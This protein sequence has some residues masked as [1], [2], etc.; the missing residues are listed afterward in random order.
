MAYEPIHLPH[1]ERFRDWFSEFLRQELAP[2]PGR[3][4]L[5]A[6]IVIS[7]TLSMI[8]IETFHIPG[9]YVGALCA[10]LFSRES[11]ISTA[12]SA[13][14]FAGAFL[15]GG[16]FIPV[17]VR[18]LDSGPE[19]HFLWVGCSLF[20]A[21]FLLRCFANYPMAVA[22]GVVIANVVGVWY[23]PQDVNVSL[24]LWLTLAT[25][26]GAVVTL[27]VEVVFRALYGS[28]DL[29]DGL[30]SRLALLEAL[31]ADLAG[32]RPVSDRT[33]A[34]LAQFAVVGAGVLRRHVVRASYAQQYRTRMATL[35]SLV[36]RA[37]DFGAALAGVSPLPE[38]LRERA[39]RV[40]HTLADIRS[41][42]RSFGRPCQLALEPR[43]SPGTPL[44][45]EIENMV[46]LMTSI[47]SGENAP[48]PE[49]HAI[50]DEPAANRIFVPDAFSNPEHLRYILGGTLAAML[51]YIIYVT[52]DWHNLSTSVTTCVLTALT[53][54]GSSRQKQ[55]MRVAG[56]VIGG[57]ITGIGAEIF[58]LPG[59]DSIGGFT[60]LF[61]L[62]TTVAA[63]VAT[64]GA[65]LSYAG[66]QI[67]FA[68]FI[69]HLSDFH[70]Q[71]DLTIARDR[72]L[73]VLLG[74]TMM[75][76]VFERLFPRSA[77]DEMVRI[78]VVN[79]RLLAD[80]SSSTPRADHPAD[81]LQLRRKREEINRHFGEVVAQADA[82]PFE[83]GSDRAGDMA[84]R[85]RIRRWQ[86][87][88]RSFYLLELPLVQFRLFGGDD[89][90]M[91]RFRDF[92]NDFRL[93]CARI[94]RQVADDLESQ[95]ATRT[96]RV[97]ATESLVEH[98]DSKLAG[99]ARELSEREKSLL[100]VVQT[101][102]QLVDRL[103]SQV[104]SEGLYDLPQ[105]PA[106]LP[107][108]EPDQA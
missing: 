12:R 80:F 22:F 52:L 34:G 70:I 9:G 44:F 84:A 89:P 86:A 57:V 13:F 17:G 10:F 31:M 41:C 56:F 78:F 26:I 96:H 97:A 105:T 91:Q 1:R 40:G 90:K 16:L 33:Q 58:I 25:L 59:I 5:V 67:A 3:G 79:L 63:W 85:D 49:L 46:S 72:V 81:L 71:T 92:E 95:L 83:T 54:I 15:L 99:A 8:L 108:A 51:C 45:S 61:V 30:D 62:V 102:A 20:I 55:T 24:T 50:E 68:F 32:A 4:T 29:L 11:L 19:T 47:F 69:I 106:F 94:F 35:V 39:T 107:A 27:C 82:V 18:L 103:Q 38:D 36:D 74:I 53:T 104:A 28:N 101:L 2:Y 66:V 76:I 43:P 88:L 7:S 14:A 73:G 98:V 21:F 48:D 77:A 87:G 37:I 60:I 42:L 93:E 75:W 6:R 65:R 100:R 23:L 64:S